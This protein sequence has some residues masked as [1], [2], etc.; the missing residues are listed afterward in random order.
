MYLSFILYSNTLNDESQ[1][2]NSTP[3]PIPKLY[4]LIPLPIALPAKP[5]SE[6]FHPKPSYISQNPT[7]QSA[8]PFPNGNPQ[9][10]ASNLPSAQLGESAWSP[11]AVRGGEGSSLAYIKSMID[12][13]IYASNDDSI[14]LSIYQ[15]YPTIDLLSTYLTVY[16]FA[17]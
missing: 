16:L 4:T 5:Q 7:S 3:S 2:L 13:A 17:N 10:P 15:V 14:Y 6:L 8:R 11:A 9:S 12:P 1:L